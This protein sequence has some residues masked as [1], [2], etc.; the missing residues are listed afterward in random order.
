MTDSDSDTESTTTSTTSGSSSDPTSDP[1]TDPTTDSDSSTGGSS[2]TGGALCGNEQVDPGEMCDDGNDTPSDGCNNDCVE[3]GSIVWTHTQA[4]G[5]MAADENWGVTTDDNG[6]PYVAGFTQAAM[7]DIDIYLRGYSAPG[8][9]RWTQTVGTAAVVDQG[10]DVEFAGGSLYFAGSVTNGNQG[11]N[12][13]FARYDLS[14][15]QTWAMT[16]TGNPTRGNGIPIPGNDGARAV[17]VGPDGNPV[18]GGFIVTNGGAQQFWVRK[19]DTAGME[20]WTEI[21]GG[22]GNDQVASLA[23]DSANNVI[24]VGFEQNASRDIAVHKLS[25]AGAE[26]W[27]MPFDGTEMLSDT[28]FGVAVTDNDDI[29]VAGVEGTSTSDGR[30]FLRRMAAMDGS[31]IWTVQ[32][33]GGTNEGAQARE[34]AIAPNGDLVVA[35]LERDTALWNAAVRRYTDDG[36][37]RWERRYDGAAMTESFALDITVSADGPIYVAGIQDLGVDVRDAW[38]AR[39]A[40]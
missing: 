1:T 16:E 5:L 25:P 19:I 37:L 32:D 34:V 40:P 8:G 29:I 14:G 18:I 2:T 33:E 10:F 3:S 38:I 39:L 26:L 22:N 9:L 30:F 15:G 20:L 24:V 11:T 23:V 12:L 27:T 4:S 7:D 35:A 6:D 36:D 31:E 28:G 21:F 17:A 13:W